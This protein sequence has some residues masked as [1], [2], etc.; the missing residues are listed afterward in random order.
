MYLAE[1]GCSPA[2]R[3]KFIACEKG[4][5]D[6]ADLEKCKEAISCGTVNKGEK[7]KGSEASAR[8]TVAP[9][10]HHPAPPPPHAAAHAPLPTKAK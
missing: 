5:T 3:D 7:E 2:E 9:A 1:H 10:A 6:D 4:V 8:G